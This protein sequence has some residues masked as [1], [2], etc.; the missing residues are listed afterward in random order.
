[1]ELGTEILILSEI[2]RGPPDTTRWI[3]STDGKAAVALSN[4]AVTAPISHSRGPGFASMLFPDLLVYSCYWR[5]GGPLNQFEGFLTNLECDIR[6]RAN[7]DVGVI[8]AGDFNAKSPSWGSDT[9]DARGQVLER[10]AASVNLWPVNSGSVPTFSVGDRSSVI[11]VTLANLIRGSSIRD[12]RVRDD[13]YSDSDHRYIQFSISP[14]VQASRRPEAHGWSVRNFDWERIEGRLRHD[15]SSSDGVVT[16]RDCGADMAAD[17]IGDYLSEVSDVA[18]PKRGRPSPRRSVFWWTEGISALRRACITSLRVYQRA[19]RRRMPRNHLKEEFKMARKTLRT[20]IRKAQEEAWRNLVNSVDTDPWGRA[21][22]IVNRKIGGTP[23]GAES[24]GRE[25]VIIEGLFPAMTPPDWS[26]NPLWANS[27]P[28]ARFTI[29]ELREAASRIPSGKSPGPDGIRNEVLSAV[30][31][32]NPAPL[33]KIFNMCLEEMTFPARWKVARIVLL[34]KGPDKSV[35][36]PASFRPI[37]LLDGMGKLFERL[38]LNRMSP[39]VSLALSPNQ[40]GFRPGSGTMSA[41]QAVMDVASDAAKGVTQDRQLCVLV[42]LDIKNAF[43][44][45]PWRAI[46]EAC[47]K[48]GLPTYL[49]RLV[50]SYLTDRYLLIPNDDSQAQKRMTC[51]V[52]QGSVLGPTLWNLFYDDLLRLRLPVGAQTVG[53]ADDLALL[54]VNHTSEGLE[55]T[56]NESLAIIDK[57]I[58]RSG[59]ALAHQKTE[60]VMLTR[61]WAYRNPVLFSG[62]HRI[63]IKRTTKYLGVV[64]D[65]KLTFTAHMKAVAASATNTAKAIGRLMPNVGGPSMAKR[66]L[67]ASVVISKL[68]YAAPVWATRSVP[69]ESNRKTLNRA[70]RLAAMRITRCY[71]T[72]STAAAL[73]LAG[74]PP[75]DLLALEREAINRA[76]ITDPNLRIAPVKREVRA[77]TLSRWQDRWDDESMVA[78]WTKRLL[79]SIARWIARP[80][81]APVTFHLAQLLTGHGVFNAYLHR[82]SIIPSPECIYCSEAVDDVEHTIFICPQWDN[83]RLTICGMLGRPIG[84]DDVG[85]LLC[86]GTSIGSTWCCQRRTFLDMVEAILENKERDERD[87]HRSNTGANAEQMDDS[88]ISNIST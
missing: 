42:T 36:D 57:W 2:P 28:G 65:S 79:P 58:T 68:L 76:R 54:V 49:R 71:R 87:R 75:G 25:R 31:K 66:S 4:L 16:A 86:G 88:I 55:A 44:S 48:I 27:D 77:T 7:P 20:E 41:I 84:P 38:V 23:P 69:F 74:I 35:T 6:A 21:Y 10:F 1:M 24:A 17:L 78:A 50:R 62:G 8:V 43:N 72:V 46:D 53:F 37:S 81:G 3:S 19:G 85:P 29:E 33:L 60:A 73:V 18:M 82:F 51:G 64:L 22:K 59:M 39:F 15:A 45:V 63:N 11:D 26:D 40:Y 47:A 83:Y 5:P 56:T 32:W 67:L 30:A 14:S 13:L 52:P 9:C 34:H 12:W 61:K 80:A 70:L